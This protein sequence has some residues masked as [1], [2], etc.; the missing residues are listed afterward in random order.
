MDKDTT[1]R[2]ECL[3]LACGQAQFAD[4]EAI[5]AVAQKLYDFCRGNKSKVKGVPEDDEIPF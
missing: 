5:A 2:I 4:G 3:R 1:L